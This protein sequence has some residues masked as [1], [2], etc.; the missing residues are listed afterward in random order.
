MGNIITQYSKIRHKTTVTGGT[1][2][3]PT[4]EDYTLQPGA[5]G[6]WTPYDLALSEIAV[7]QNS[8]RA[9][10]RMGG[11]ISE[12]S[13]GGS[14][15]SETLAQTLVLGNVTGGTD[16]LL[17]G[18]NSI[19]STD[20]LNTLQLVDNVGSSMISNWGTAFGGMLIGPTIQGDPISGVGI[21]YQDVD[22]SVFDFSGDGTA[23]GLGVGKFIKWSN[24]GNDKNATVLL[25]DELTRIQNEHDGAYSSFLTLESSGVTL[26][27][28]TASFANGVEITESG[29][30]FSSDIGSYRFPRENGL[31]GQI[32]EN[33]G[34]NTISWATPSGGGYETLAETLAL[35]NDVGGFLISGTSGN[36][37][38]ALQLTDSNMS[39]LAGG[40]TILSS[41]GLDT[42]LMTPGTLELSTGSDHITIT[43]AGNTEIE[44]NGYLNVNGLYHLNATVA[45]TNATVTTIDS[46]NI[47]G[48]GASASNIVE[49]YIT[50]VEDDGTQVYGAKLFA[51]VF[52]TNPLVTAVIIGTVDVVEKTTFTTATSTIDINSGTVRVRV[53]GEAGTNIT[54]YCKMIY[55]ND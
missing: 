21:L 51:T 39:I 23:F 11:T 7:D 12:F 8:Q 19:S 37:D 1:F 24:I 55:T 48:M 41:D 50:G 34:A 25:F 45:T 38:F 29:V 47:G 17:S 44:P 27:Y 32:L 30:G 3:I 9:F 13:F 2:S 18:T 4:Q 20:G 42:Q 54:W 15:S 28:I 35:G 31:A 16:I 5:S 52:S 36:D 10:I 6:S 26:G 53:T 49:A 43:S 40:N 46:V 22:N 14:A 33:D